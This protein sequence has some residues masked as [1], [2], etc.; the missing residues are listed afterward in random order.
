MVARIK[1]NKK[2]SVKSILG[3]FVFA[4]ATLFI[5]VFFIA[6]NWKIYQKRSELTKRVEELRAQVDT[7]EKRNKELKENLSDVGTEDYLEKVAREQLDMKKPGEEVVVIQK[8]EEQNQPEQE[9]KKSWW[10]IIKSLWK[11]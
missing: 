7:L 11:K 5:I 3:Y 10:E 9:E 2:S 8:E 6:T 4:I 1:R